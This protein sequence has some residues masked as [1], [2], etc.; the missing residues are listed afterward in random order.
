MSSGNLFVI[1]GPSGAGKG[2][3]CKAFT[4]KHPEAYLSIS[5]TTRKPRENEVHG[6]NYYFMSEEGFRSEIARGGFLEYAVYCGNYYGTPRV[7][8]LEQL[9]AGRDVI[10]EIESSGA[11]Q[12]R[13]HCPEGVFIFVCPPSFEILKERLMKRGTESSEVI[14]ARLKKAEQEF[15]VAGKYNYMLLNDSVE[16]AVGRLEAIIAA[17][18]CYMPRNM[19]FINNFIKKEI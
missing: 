16:Q 2:T 15:A 1:S 10:L 9:E 8:V 6:V 17:E 11:M 4:E 14:E 5:A 19:D 18:K 12:V 3:I 7:K 13:S